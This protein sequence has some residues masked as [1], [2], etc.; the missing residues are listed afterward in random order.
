MD[1][2]KK[3]RGVPVTCR[4]STSD[5]HLE[6]ISDLSEYN[7]VLCGT[8]PIGIDVD[9]S[10]MDIILEVYDFNGFEEKVKVLYGDLEGFR[11]KRKTIR[12][13]PIIK[14]NFTDLGMEYELFGQRQPVEKQYAYLHMVIE[15][16]LLE[17]VPGLRKKVIQLK[18]Q[19]IKTEPAF[20]E[21]LGIVGD[22]YEGLIEFGKKKGII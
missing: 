18:K 9:G 5:R 11:I 16:V 14:A 8:F 1:H 15:K 4:N 3:N 20:C 12:N 17:E 2:Q 10:D 6:I 13:Q 7:P 22:P 21:V 19:G